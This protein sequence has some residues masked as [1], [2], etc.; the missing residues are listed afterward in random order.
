MGR[1]LAD[2]AERTLPT[3]QGNAATYIDALGKQLSAHAPGDKFPYQFKIVNDGNINSFALPGG[4]IY[5]TKGLVEAAQSEQQ[6][7]GA[8]AHELGHVVLRHGTAEVSQA[9]NGQANSTQA[10]STRRR[11]SVSEVMSR[12]NIRFEPDSIATRYSREEERQADLVATQIM[13]DTGF[14]P[15][16]MTQFFQRISSERSSLTSD[17]FNN[18][19]GATNRGARVRGELQKI[20]PLPRNL[21][22]DS[23]DFHSVKDRLTAMARP[24]TSSRSAI[25]AD[26]D[27]GGRPDLPSSRFVTYRG[28][29]AEIRYPD[30][31]RVYEESGDAISLAPENG[32]VS[33]MLAYGMR[34]ATFEPQDTRSFGRSQFSTQGRPAIAGTNLSRATDQLLDE[35]R[36]SN[37]RMSVV[38]TNDWR[39]V[40]GRPAMAI[41]LTNDSPLGGRE[42]NWLVTVLRADG[43]LQYFVG[44]APQQDFSRYQGTFEQI[45]SSARLMD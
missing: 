32:M 2:Q 9:Y 18:H 31:W 37:P 24:N 36:Q 19:P 41:E 30:N 17:F 38:R 26:R 45:V 43:L 40:D 29:D 33:G 27:D 8:I 14:D 15:S 21:R 35:L 44:V 34:I 7:A 3:V 5:V 20:G 42:T 12:L 23:P 28:R 1:A 16:H 39:T 10:N 25:N 4:F 22:G 11:P 6:L 13:Y